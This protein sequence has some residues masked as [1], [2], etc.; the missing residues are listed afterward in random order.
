MAKKTQHLIDAAL[1]LAAEKGWQAVTLADVAVRAKQPLAE[2]YVH[3]QSRNDILRAFLARIDEQ[4]MSGEVDA[5]ASPRD[6]VFEVTMRR[7]EALTPHKQAVRSILRQGVDPVTALCGARRFARS[8]A[9]LLEA[10]GIGSAG[11]TG[12]VRVNGMA[13]IYLYTMRCWLRD[14]TPD[15]ARTMAALDTALRRADSVA[16][17]LRRCGAARSSHIPSA[18]TQPET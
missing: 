2:V 9:L 12:L 3:F 5:D 14:D 13:A 18:E 6:R 15:L 10:A 17:S 16:G 11:L 4:M 8:M 1:D 7:F